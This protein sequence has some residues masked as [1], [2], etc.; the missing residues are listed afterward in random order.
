MAS[1]AD[2]GQLV[3]GEERDSFPST[4]PSNWALAWSPRLGTARTSRR[5]VPLL[6]VVPTWEN[7]PT[8][9]SQT[10][11]KASLSHFFFYKEL[12]VRPL[13]ASLS[14]CENQGKKRT[15]WQKGAW[16][17]VA[18]I[19]AF[20]HSSHFLTLSLRSYIWNSGVNFCHYVRQKVACPSPRHGSQ[21]F[22]IIW[23]KITTCWVCFR[24]S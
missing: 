11:F 6:V 24:G 21:T 13:L 8:K 16:Q 10:W 18:N 2:L 1:P 17:K 15:Q 4:A 22:K 20:C 12:G 9:I 23:G 19:G 5:A 14:I 3:T 7:H